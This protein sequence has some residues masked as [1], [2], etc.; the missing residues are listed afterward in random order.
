MPSGGLPGPPAGLDAAAVQLWQELAAEAPWLTLADRSSVEDLTRLYID[1]G[2]LRAAVRERGVVIE[3][4]IPDPRGGVVG[5]RLVANPAAALALRTQAAIGSLRA[6]LGLS[7]QSRAR[8]GLLTLQGRTEVS[9]LEQFLEVAAARSR[10]PR[11][12]S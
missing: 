2:D 8:L 3:E 12:V 9:K 11:N 7:P 4:V 6:S 1:L 5:T 10:G